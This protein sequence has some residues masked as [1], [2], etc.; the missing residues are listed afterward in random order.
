V[1]AVVAVVALML[2]AGCA[3][4]RPSASSSSGKASCAELYTRLQQ[5]SATV[6]ATSE[7]LTNSL[8]SQQLSNGIAVEEQQLRQ[9][10]QLMASAPVPDTLTATNRQLVSA[11]QAM[12]ADFARA[13]E[14]AARGDFEAASQAMT[15]QAAVQHI[16]DASQK[17]EA[18]CA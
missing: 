3:S 16:V 4:T 2:A 5:V 6:S 8:G 9:S 10:A 15:D 18:A 13:E 1:R 12:A 11:L 17:I 14:P 7:L